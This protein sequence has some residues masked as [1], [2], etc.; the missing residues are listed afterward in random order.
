MQFNVSD[1]MYNLYKIPGLELPN[2]DIT[3]KSKSNI[4]AVAYLFT[5]SLDFGKLVDVQQSYITCQIFIVWQ[6]SLF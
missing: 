4:A 5:S 1:M 6:P 2:K 3:Q